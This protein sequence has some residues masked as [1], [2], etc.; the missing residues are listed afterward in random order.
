M[1]REITL[2]WL[3]WNAWKPYNSSLLMESLELWEY[4]NLYLNA[5]PTYRLRQRKT[6][7]APGEIFSL[8]AAT[9][10][11]LP[12]PKDMMVISLSSW[13]KPTV[14]RG[15][16]ERITP[17]LSSEFSEL[18]GTLVL[19][20]S[21]ADGTA[22]GYS[23]VDIA[24]FPPDEEFVGSF[25]K[26]RRALTGAARVIL[27][28]DHLQHHGIFVIPES[29]AR[30]RS[31]LPPSAFH[32]AVVLRGRNEITTGGWGASR[33]TN[34]EPI[35]KKCL[36]L[37]ENPRKRPLNLYG[38]KLFLSQLML[39][40]SLF[41]LAVSRDVPKPESFALIREMFPEDCVALD[42]ATKIRASW[43]RPQSQAFRAGLAL[44]PSPWDFAFAFRRF[45]R[46]DKGLMEALD[47]GFYR[48]AGRLAWRMRD[49]LER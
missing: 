8:Y 33:W 3:V 7:I 47:E 15:P 37:A 12:E 49:A 30:N 34:L 26:I 6:G 38:I 5:I 16:D 43:K 27:S 9:I 17:A 44:W 14:Q 13:Q 24:Y 1:A 4:A 11:K 25:G 20:G 39:L 2:G 21:L 19:M 23:D 42:L 31:P 22:T 40:P 36:S 45:F 48:A 35:I 32:G 29:L 10:P 46:P 41:L 28:F 18:S